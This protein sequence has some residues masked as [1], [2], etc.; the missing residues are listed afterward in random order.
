MPSYQIHNYT[1]PDS[2]NGKQ[3]GKV[4]LCNIKSNS[5]LSDLPAIFRRANNHE[6]MC[7]T[8]CMSSKTSKTSSATYQ[9]GCPMKH[10][11]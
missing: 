10:V 7:I 9:H 5:G 4:E 1:F 3:M 8:K 6:I 11:S 2:T